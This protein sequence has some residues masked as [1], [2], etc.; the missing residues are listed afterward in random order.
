M[1]IIVRKKVMK[2][3]INYH[4]QK[5]KNT[6]NIVNSSPHLQHTIDVLIIFHKSHLSSQSGINKNYKLEPMFTGFPLISRLKWDFAG[7]RT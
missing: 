4:D 7:S 6:K 2:K 3:Q 5:Y 1:F